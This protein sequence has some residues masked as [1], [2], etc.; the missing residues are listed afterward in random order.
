MKWLGMMLMAAL[1][2]VAPGYGIAAPPG[3]DSTSPATQSK[4]LGNRGEQAQ[5]VKSY[6]PE[7]KRAYQ[8]KVAADLEKIQQGIGELKVKGRTV[9]PQQKRMVLRALIGLQNKANAARNKLAALEN[10]P[11]SSWSG[12][13]ADMDK[14]MANLTK[15]Y[16]EVEAHL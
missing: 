4:D 3:K 2:I 5:A 12:L 13:K 7:E 16:K 1:L 10:T 9:V 14:A 15:T 8:K 11:E 6:T